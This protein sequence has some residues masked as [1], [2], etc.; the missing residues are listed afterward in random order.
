MFSARSCRRRVR[1]DA[2]L[3]GDGLQ[4]RDALLQAFLDFQAHLFQQVVAGVVLGN[5]P[6]HA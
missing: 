1:F 2:Q 5:R 4:L 3:I 6:L